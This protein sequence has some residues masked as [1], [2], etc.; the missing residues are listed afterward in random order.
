[1]AQSEFHVFMTLHIFKIFNVF[2]YCKLC[3]HEKPSERADQGPVPPIILMCAVIK[4]PFKISGSREYDSDPCA[5]V[6][7]FGKLLQNLSTAFFELFC[8]PK[9]FTYNCLSEV[10]DTLKQYHKNLSITLVLDIIWR[11]KQYLAAH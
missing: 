10:N 3:Q 9:P 4:N 6:D 7:I 8:K 2:F 1:M 5:I 11:P